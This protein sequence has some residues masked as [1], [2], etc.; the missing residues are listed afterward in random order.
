MI[1]KKLDFNGKLTQKE[2]YPSNNDGSVKNVAFLLENESDVVFDG[3]GQTFTFD[4]GVSP[5]ILDGCKNVTIKNFNIDYKYPQHIEGDVV[6]VGEKSFLLKIRDGFSASV[7]NGEFQSL[8]GKEKTLHGR[9][10]CQEFDPERKAPYANTGYMYIQCLKSDDEEVDERWI[11]P[12]YLSE[13]DGCIEFKLRESFKG[14]FNVHLGGRLVLMLKDR[15]CSGIFINDCQNVSVENVN[16]FRSPSMGVICQLSKNV[17]LNGVRVK[18]KVGRNEVLSS[19]ADATHFVNCSGLVKIVDCSFYNM[20]DDGCNIHGIY[21]KVTKVCQDKIAVRL[22]HG[23]QRGVKYINDGDEIVFVSSKDYT[24]RAKA[25]VLKSVLSDEKDEIFVTVKNVEGEILEGF[26]V[27][28]ITAMPEVYVSGCSTG[29]NRP[30]GFL[31]TSVKPMVIENCLFE[32]MACGIHVTSDARDWYES[33]KVDGLIIRNNEFR[34]CNYAWGTAAI[35]IDPSSDEQGVYVHKNILVENNVLN[36]FGYGLVYAKAVDGL[37]IKDNKSN[38]IY[39]ERVPEVKF[40][41]IEINNCKN[42]SID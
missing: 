40:P 20:L 4:D 6:E 28:N 41:L 18:V 32:N 39:S 7:V 2:Y 30:R 34:G 19:N 29:S 10:F 1:I 37:V 21:G 38:K 3:Q 9:L 27:D 17:T 36:T 12:A 25:T 35:V 14:R 42:V 22:M 16:I 31:L 26:V 33:G 8:T 11:T 15:Q 23:Q 13:K 5:F 24:H